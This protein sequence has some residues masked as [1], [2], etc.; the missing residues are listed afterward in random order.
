MVNYELADFVIMKSLTPLH[1]G[2]GRGG[3][4]VDL[5]IQKDELGFPMVYSSS[6]KGALKSTISGRL[7]TFLFGP[8]VEEEKFSAPIAL[9]DAYL[10]AFPVRS[11]MGVYGYATA[12]VL[13]KRSKDYLDL[14]ASLTSRKSDN[15]QQMGQI[16][17]RLS[18]MPVRKGNVYVV[19]KDLFFVTQLSRVVVNEELQLEQQ[20]DEDKSKDLIKIADALKIE[21]NR[22]MLLS[23]EDITRAVE[24]SLQKV[25]RVKLQRETKTAENLWTEEYIPRETAFCMA[26]LYSRPQ[27]PDKLGEELNRIFENRQPEAEDVRGKLVDNLRMRRNY[28]I[29]GGHE[30]IGRGIVNL[31]FMCD[32]L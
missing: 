13:L 1:P 9:L 27:V 5:P 32:A 6:V 7:S 19:E 4:L 22:L 24:K 28:L 31:I 18:S 14:V 2:V 23:D 10:L 30:T 29:I 26:I 11:L 8:E 12:P 15:L 25:T 16:I 20:F 21:N 17:D 3:E